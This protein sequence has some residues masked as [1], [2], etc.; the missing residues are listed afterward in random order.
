MVYLADFQSLLGSGQ[1]RRLGGQGG[2]L[3]GRAYREAMEKMAEAGLSQ[4]RIEAFFQRPVVI[5]QPEFYWSVSEALAAL[6]VGGY[7]AGEGESIPTH[8]GR[9]VAWNKSV[10]ST[11]RPDV[12]DILEPTAEQLPSYEIEMSFR[13]NSR[14]QARNR[15]IIASNIDTARIRSDARDAVELLR[16]RPNFE[17]GRP[18]ERDNLRL[19]YVIPRYR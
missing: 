6:D 18:K 4:Q 1:E 9:F 3:A 12:P 15:K 5:P 14:G 19:T 2:Q 13:L 11:A 7:V 17:E 16:F 8:L 10:P